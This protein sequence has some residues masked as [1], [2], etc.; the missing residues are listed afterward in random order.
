MR[1]KNILGIEID[2]IPKYQILEKIKKYL[3][4]GKDFV[5]IVSVNPENIVIAQENKEF[6]KVINTAQIKIRDGVGIVLA[7]KILGIPVGER[8]T[9]VDLMKELIA[10]AS[11]M[12]LRV[13]LIGGKPNLANTLAN[14]YQ[15]AYPQAK[16]VGFEA[17]KNIKK[18]D[19]DEERKLFSIVSALKPHLVFVAFG[20]PDQELWLERHKDKFEGSVCMGVG[21]A[22]DY[23]SGRVPRA[24]VFMRN[25]GFEWLFRLVNQPWR[26]RR[27]LRLVKFLWLVARERI[28]QW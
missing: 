8:V 4:Q 16:F 1:T 28:K 9:G 5:H 7:G 14:C 12:S 13:L 11:K 19:P 3:Y 10:I 20:S 6:K 2:N 22:F 24:P 21:G 15:Q 17:I 25:L 18:I 23:L 27:Q 26:W